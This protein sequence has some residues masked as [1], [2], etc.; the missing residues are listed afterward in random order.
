MKKRK[1]FADIVLFILGIAV[2]LFG[3]FYHSHGVY[4]DVF[5]MTDDTIEKTV[6]VQMSEPLPIDDQNWLLGFENEEDAIEL[7]IVIPEKYVRSMDKYARSP[8][9]VTGILRQATQEMHDASYAAL[10]DYIEMIAENTED[11]EVSEEEKENL[12]NYISPYYIEV[13]SL[14]H[15]ANAML[16]HIAWIAGCVLLFLA[17]IV[18]ISLLSGKSALKLLL[19]V[20]AVIAIPAVIAGIVFFNKIRTVCSIRSDDDGVYY[21]EHYG[22]YKLDEMLDAGI[23]TDEAMIDWIRKTELC[24]LPVKINLPDFACAS[25]KAE[26]PEGNIL[27]GRN[28]DYP[29]TDTLM[30]YSHPKE[31]YASYSMADLETCGIEKK[32][33][34]VDPDSL[35]GRILMLIAP[36]AVCDGVNEAGLGVTTLEL[37]IGELHQDTD[38][39]ELYVYTAVRLLLDRCATVDEAIKLLEGYDIHSHSGTRQ[40]L[41]IADQSGRSVVVEWFEN[42]MFVN[43]LDAV[44]NSVLTP[45]DH[46]DE[47]A[48]GRLPK[49]TARLAEMDGVLT[50]EQARDLQETVAHN[51]EWS[52]VYNLNDFSVDL[53]VDE[54]YTKAYHYGGKN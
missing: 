54:D 52:C 34:K 24:N 15:G 23:T 53:Y 13:T 27:I 16:N 51:T 44:T 28:F 38:K 21:M 40:H 20:I 3:K 47:G 49:I 48:D 2:L 8:V 22:D 17:V 33:G 11:Y 26:T 32:N 43:E 35:T 9:P 41:F 39:P 42:E 12:H 37:D 14:N 6:T 46:F 29:E 5:S 10:L 31:G 50:P 19:I 18:L 4:D 1:I 30:I 25:F 45:G 36:Y 7:L